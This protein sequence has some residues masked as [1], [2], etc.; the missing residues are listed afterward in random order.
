MED[1]SRGKEEDPAEA[2]PFVRMGRFQGENSGEG[3][4][5]APKGRAVQMLIQR[6][7]CGCVSS[8]VKLGLRVR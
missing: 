3:P 4:S 6:G 5:S 7:L 8:G 2:I 1:E